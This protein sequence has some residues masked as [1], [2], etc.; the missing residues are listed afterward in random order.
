[1]LEVKLYGLESHLLYNYISQWRLCLLLC[2]GCY[3]ELLHISLQVN[4]LEFWNFIIWWLDFEESNVIL[5]W[6]L[7]R[8]CLIW[9]YASHGFHH[10]W[11]VHDLVIFFVLLGCYEKIYVI[12]G[13]W[14]ELEGVGRPTSLLI[15]TFSHPLAQF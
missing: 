5:D 15:L 6:V 7:H 8:G 13:A 12:M 2:I 14:I 11:M 3:L 10:V 4:I 9:V 1:L